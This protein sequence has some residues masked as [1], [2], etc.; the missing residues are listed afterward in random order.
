MEF[1]TRSFEWN[2]GPNIRGYTSL[3]AGNTV[4]DL[5]VLRILRIT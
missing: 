3:H 5:R 2:G 4:L 1:I